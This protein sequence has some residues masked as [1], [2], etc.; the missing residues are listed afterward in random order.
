MKGDKKC[1]LCRKPL[2]ADDQNE[3]LSAVSRPSHW[4]SRHTTTAYHWTL[5]IT[6]HL[7]RHRLTLALRAGCL[8]RC[9]AWGL[10]A[11]VLVN[12]SAQDQRAQA[13]GEQESP[14]GCKISELVRLVKEMA[15]KNPGVYVASCMSARRIVCTALQ[16]DLSQPR[17]Q[18]YES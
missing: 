7:T 5:H 9:T 12:V 17:F 2:T 1:P 14:Y 11:C 3:V 6:A 15:S 4:Q 18:L 16:P 13:E 8:E 10:S